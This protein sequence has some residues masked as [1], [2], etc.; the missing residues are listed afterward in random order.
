[1]SLS[2]LKYIKTMSDLKAKYNGIQAAQKVWQKKII[3]TTEL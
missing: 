3:L 2:R 1:M